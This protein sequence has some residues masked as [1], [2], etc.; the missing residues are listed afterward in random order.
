VQV[1]R[2]ELPDLSFH[3]MKA[4][5]G[6]GPRSYP[7]GGNVQ[8]EAAA[9]PKNHTGAG[10]CRPERIQLQ[11]QNL[12]PAVELSSEELG[13]Q[14]RSSPTPGSQKAF[15]G[16]LWVLVASASSSCSV[17]RLPTLSNGEKAKPRVLTPSAQ[18]QAGSAPTASPQFP[19]P[20][21]PADEPCEHAD[22]QLP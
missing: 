19:R 22:S 4:R 15:E 8:M 6:S 5:A 21:P 14:D 17:S 1:W 16:Y 3:W 18:T 12:I 9:T 11:Q 20:V 13:G 2:A 10:Q 7:S